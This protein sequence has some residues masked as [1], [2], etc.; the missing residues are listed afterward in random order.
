MPGNVVARQFATMERVVV[1]AYGAQ[2]AFARIVGLFGAL[3]LALAVAGAYGVTSYL[4]SRRATEIGIRMALGAR[5]GAVV[6]AVLRRCLLLGGAG[7]GVGSG[8]AWLATPSLGGLILDVAPSDPPTFLLVGAGLLAAV[9]LA[10]VVPA[11]RAARVD[12]LDALRQQ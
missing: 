5:S 10:G 2:R 8:L 3:A 7:V 11:R 6:G 4:V 1:D 12:P 9:T